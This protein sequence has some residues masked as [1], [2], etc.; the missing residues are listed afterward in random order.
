MSMGRQLP[1][2]EGVSMLWLPNMVNV[3]QRRAVEG[4]MDPSMALHVSVSDCSRS[5]RLQSAAPFVMHA[6]HGVLFSGGRDM[7]ISERSVFH[8]TSSR[9]M[10]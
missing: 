3:S 6:Y 9:L 10:G 1:D 4:S 8:D 5:D 7:A 2:V